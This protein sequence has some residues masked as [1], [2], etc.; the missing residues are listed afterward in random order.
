MILD[1]VVFKA[2]D[3]MYNPFQNRLSAMCK[4]RKET[5]V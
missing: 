3:Y 2:I 4:Y 5:I 1:I